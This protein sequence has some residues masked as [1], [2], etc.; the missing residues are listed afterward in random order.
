MAD[1]MPKPDYMSEEEYKDLEDMKD[2]VANIKIG[3]F[4]YM[5][6]ALRYKPED[7]KH[8]GHKDLPSMLEYILRARKKDI[9]K[10]FKEFL[11][12]YPD[13]A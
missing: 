8:S 5:E 3:A 11:K 10:A 1:R 6:S 13:K 9:D 2:K 7:F 4:D 12:K